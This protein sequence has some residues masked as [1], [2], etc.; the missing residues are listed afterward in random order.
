MK[1]KEPSR[2]A[3]QDTASMISSVGFTGRVRSAG[4]NQSHR[5]RTGTGPN[6]P[7]LNLRR[8]VLIC[9]WALPALPPEAKN[10]KVASGEKMKTKVPKC[11]NSARSHLRSYFVTC[12]NDSK[13]RSCHSC[14]RFAQKNI[15]NFIVFR[16]R[17]ASSDIIHHNSAPGGNAVLCGSASAGGLLCAQ[18]S[19]SVG[20]NRHLP[21]TCLA[22]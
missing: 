15:K 10:H 19:D 11:T 17:V 13:C 2:Q 4:S 22:A 6:C 21:S 7:S 14:H 5:L 12:P 3:S 16:N 1:S 8:S 18:L 9:I 20:S